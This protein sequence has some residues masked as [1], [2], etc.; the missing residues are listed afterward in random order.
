MIVVQAD[1]GGEP[2]VLVS[3]QSW[4]DRASD[5]RAKK[6]QD[7]V[8]TAF[9]PT[10]VPAKGTTSWLLVG[11]RLHEHDEPGDTLV[12]YT[13]LLEIDR[14]GAIAGWWHE[15][16]M[17]VPTSLWRVSGTLAGHTLALSLA[18]QPPAAVEPRAVRALYYRREPPRPAPPRPA[19]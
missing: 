4:E 11:H 16:H 13:L 12:T 7:A 3:T 2:V 10:L 1:L 14:T 6:Q 9:T 18:G 5:P 19:R 15:D 17:E 8:T